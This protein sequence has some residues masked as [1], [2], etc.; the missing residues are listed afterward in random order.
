MRHRLI[1]LGLCLAWIA[2]ESRF[3]PDFF[4]SSV[5]GNLATAMISLYA[6]LDRAEGEAAVVTASQSD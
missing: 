5:R 2:I 4:W 3:S 1:L 6:G